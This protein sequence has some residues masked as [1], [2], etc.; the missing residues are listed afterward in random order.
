MDAGLGKEEI[1]DL[2]K[3]YDRRFLWWT[4]KE[5]E[6]GKKIKTDKESGIDVLIEII[7]WKFYTLPGRIKR[8]LNLISE[9]SDNF[10]RSVTRQAISM[11]TKQDDKRIKE[12]RARRK[13]ILILK[14]YLY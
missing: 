12:L 6:L 8:T 10:V 9:H 11:T 4:Q 2:S 7:E 13:K 1:L 5:N 3:E 14:F